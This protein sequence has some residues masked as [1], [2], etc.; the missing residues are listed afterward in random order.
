MVNRWLHVIPPEGAA[1]QAALDLYAAAMASGDEAVHK[2]FDTLPYLEGF[3]ALLKEPTDDMRVDLMNQ[4][5]VVAALE[6]VITHVSVTSL[7][8]ITLFTLNL[9]GKQGLFLTHWMIEDYRTTDYWRKVLPGYQAVFAIQTGEIESECARLGIHFAMLPTAYSSALEKMTPPPWSS[10]PHDFVFIG[11]PS[12]YRLVV[13]DALL[14]AGADLR[15]GGL[16]WDGV[17]GP[18]RSCVLEGDFS[19]PEASLAWQAKAKYGLHIPYEN[20]TSSRAQMHIS[21]RHYDMLALGCPLVCERGPLI[22]AALHDYPC[23]WYAGPQE[24][25]VA[26]QNAGTRMKNPNEQAKLQITAEKCRGTESYARR[27]KNFSKELENL[28]PKHGRLSR[29]V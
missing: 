23:Y 6:H 16:G 17:T 14:K 10:R 5:L 19:H 8:P 1:R 9:L 12:P 25:I 29:G 27:W 4:A 3:R 20:P 21:P 28:P 18:L 26:W 7:A 13:L 2:P 15:V 24:A 11:L 22:E